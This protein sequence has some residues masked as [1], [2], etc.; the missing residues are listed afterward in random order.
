M[1]DLTDGIEY[2]GGIRWQ[3]L[4]CLVSAWII[5]F[6]C[7]LRGIKTSGKVVYITATLPYV[8]LTILLIRGL[9]MPGAMDG[10]RF[11]II[12][13]FELLKNFSVSV[14]YHDHQ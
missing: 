1:H 14:I 4:L 13:D 3:L 2:F 6:F 9:L 12:P 5:V 7:V 11:Y 10:I 8:F